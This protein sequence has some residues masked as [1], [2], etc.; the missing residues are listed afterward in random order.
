MQKGNKWRRECVVSN[1]VLLDERRRGSVFR[2]DG[3]RCRWPYVCEI[4]G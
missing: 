4:E 2:G 3:H 1:V